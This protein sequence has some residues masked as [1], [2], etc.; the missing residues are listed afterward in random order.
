V[1]VVIHKQLS[2]TFNILRG[3][4]PA[5]S[6][7]LYVVHKPLADRWVR[8]VL[9]H[10]VPLAVTDGSR[11]R[12]AWKVVASSGVRVTSIDREDNPSTRILGVR[13]QSG[14]RDTT[15]TDPLGLVWRHRV[16]MFEP[17]AEVAVTV[18]TERPDDVVFLMHPD[19]RF[20][21]RPNGDNTYSGLW[22]VPPTTGVKHIGVNALARGTVFGDAP[23]S[24][25][26]WLWHYVVRGG[27]PLAGNQ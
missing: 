2:G 27:D 25:Q 4:V 11:D 7:E 12:T 3:D 23:Y 17:E 10:R 21:L 18:T 14:D 22:R 16:M 20:F 9:L 26:A 6:A 1:L 8:R 24:S 15:I 5:D 13:V 19:R